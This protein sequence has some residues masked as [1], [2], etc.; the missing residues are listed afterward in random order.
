[1]TARLRPALAAALAA[2]FGALLLQ[3]SILTAP[4]AAAG[5]DDFS[6][7]SWDADYEVGV[8]AAGRA[9]MH[10]TETLV[11]RFP[12]TDQNRGIVRGLAEQYDGV[13]LSPTVLSIRDGDGR[14]VPYETDSEN[15]VLMLALG[16]DSY[17]HGLTTYVIKYTMR[18]VFHRPD[19]AD[20]DEFYWDL[21]PL[22]STQPI[23]SFTGRVR[24]DDT[25]ADRLTGDRGCYQ[26]YAGAKGRCDLVPESDDPG[27]FSVSVAN[28]QA[29]E[30]VTVAFAFAQGTVVPSPAKQPDAM[31]DIVPYGVAG[32]GVVL[33]TV[34]GFGAQAMLRRRH[35]KQGK[36]IVVAQ[37][38]VP[39]E[40]P[41]LLAAPVLGINGRQLQSEIVHLGVRGAL[42]IEDQTGKPALTL[43]DPALAPDPLDAAAVDA[44]FPRRAPGD[45]VHL[46]VPDNDVVGRLTAL[47]SASRAAAEERG[48]MVRRRSPLASLFGVIGVLLGL[49]GVGLS[50]PG[51]L[52]GRKA[53]IAAFVVSILLTAVLLVIALVLLQKQRVV[54]PKGAE[55]YEYLQGVRE[56]IRLAE[57]DRIRMLQSYSG[58]ERRQDGGVDVIVIYERLLPYALLFGLEKEWAQALSVAYEREHHEPAWYTGYAYGAIGSSLARM[59]GTLMPTPTAT[60]SSTSSGAFGGGF[61]GGGGGGGFSGG[62]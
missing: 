30:G 6:Y 19:D 1:M 14:D 46:A 13:P 48:L 43:L 61:S 31:T 18:D 8:D 33:A 15:D 3:A 5:V 44:L 32:G 23:E 37:Y 21:L 52:V 53:A 62:R 4:P 49:L 29:G 57:T 59:G 27:A 34:A 51:M 25:I 16:D 39:D 26:G 36:G 35:R 41:P 28:L 45:Q 58:A 42:R 54:T 20:V 55:T 10:V 17:R 50:V 56:Y 60:S 9:T 12:E 40:L 22:D 24:F 11:A 7:A 38:D 2:A 47:T